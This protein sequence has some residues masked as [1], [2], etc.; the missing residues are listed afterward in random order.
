MKITGEPSEKFHGGWPRGPVVDSEI[1]IGTLLRG[2]SR[3]GSSQS[4]S[5]HTFS[6]TEAIRDAFGHR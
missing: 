6:F 4:Y 1:D 2:T 3:P 5:H